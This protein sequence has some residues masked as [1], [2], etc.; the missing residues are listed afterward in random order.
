MTYLSNL[1]IHVGKAHAVV[2]TDGVVTV[3]VECF[4]RMAESVA[5]D[6]NV[7]WAITNPRRL[8]AYE[9][10]AKH[11]RTFDSTYGLDALGGACELLGLPALQYNWAACRTEIASSLGIAIAP[12]DDGVESVDEVANESIAADAAAADHDGGNGAAAAAQACPDGA[13]IDYDNLSRLDLIALLHKKDKDIKRLGDKVVSLKS[14]LGSAREAHRFARQLGSKK[15]KRIAKSTNDN[16][17]VGTLVRKKDATGSAKHSSLLSVTEFRG[18]KGVSYSVQGGLLLACRRALSNA[19]ARGLGFALLRGTHHSTVTSWE[20]KCRASMVGAMWR[21]Y[22]YL[23]Y[24]LFMHANENKPGWKFVIHEYRGDAT[25]S[26]VWQECKLHTTEVSSLFVGEPVMEDSEFEDVLATCES[27]SILGDLQIVHDGT[28]EGTLGCLRKQLAS[29]G[30]IIDKASPLMPLPNSNHDQDISSCSPGALCDLSD[31]AGVDAHSSSTSLRAIADAVPG[32][33]VLSVPSSSSGPS[34]VG[35]SDSH[36]AGAEDPDTKP[37]VMRV[38]QVWLACTDAGGDEHKARKY[39]SSATRHLQH[40]LFLDLDCWLHQY[41]LMV[42]G[43]LDLCDQLMLTTFKA[44]VR[45]Y[46]SLS[47]LLIVWRDKA[48]DVFRCWRSLY[49][50]VEALKFASRKP[51]KAIRGRW[52]AISNCERFCLAPPREHLI[53]VL[54]RV[55]SIA[56]IRMVDKRVAIEKPPNGNQ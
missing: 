2:A 24:D 29:V 17:N 6:M 1:I 10:V 55:P 30:A 46:S 51:P 45:F 49:G 42:K 3:P 37:E 48:R 14:M 9:V 54:I 11:W 26:S 50:D 47:K 53:A 52:G 40:V 16:A 36:A 35:P 34:A 18:R 19:S 8:L 23:S 56:S 15:K 39:I 31:A 13:G 25:N 44:E 5:S 22:K 38:L 28:A 20:V 32:P 7:A 43:G 27:R 12:V 33:S 4:K 21:F 41:Q